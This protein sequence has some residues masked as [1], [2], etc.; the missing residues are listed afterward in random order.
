ME[1]YFF[2]NV[3]HE[4]VSRSVSSTSNNHLRVSCL[5]EVVTSVLLYPGELC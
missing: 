2:S 4:Y 3:F 5:Y 1:G